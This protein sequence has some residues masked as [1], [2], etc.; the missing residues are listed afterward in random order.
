MNQFAEAVDISSSK[1]LT[2]KEQ[3]Q[4]MLQGLKAAEDADNL[5]TQELFGGATQNVLRK[6]KSLVNFEHILHLI[7][8]MKLTSIINVNY[9]LFG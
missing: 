5:L 2:A 4:K 7:S 8:T 3:R 9:L 6:E 1:P